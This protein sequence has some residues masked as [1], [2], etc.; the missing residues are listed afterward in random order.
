[1]SI[2]KKPNI[3]ARIGRWFRDTKGELK[4]VVWP[5]RK[6]LINNT[7]IVLAAVIA[8]GIVMAGLDAAFMVVIHMFLPYV[9][10]LF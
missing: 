3:F 5:T 9:I 1:M 2:E 6:Q 4:R 10:G 7:L 8:V